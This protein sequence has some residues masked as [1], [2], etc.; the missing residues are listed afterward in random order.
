MKKKVISSQLCN[1]ATY[2]MYK[3]QMLTLAENVFEFD[4]LPTYIDTAYMNNVLFTIS[5]T[6]FH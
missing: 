5:N 2:E 6:N 3:R 1:K 4:N